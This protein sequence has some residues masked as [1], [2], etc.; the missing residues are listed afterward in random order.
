MTEKTSETVARLYELIDDIETAMLVTRRPD[1]SLVSRP[2]ANQERAPGA[3]FWFAAE[4]DSDKVEEIRADP[5]VNLTYYK[6]R[7]REW[8]SVAGTAEVSKDRDKIRQLY[9][10]DW[11][12]WFAGL[13]ADDPEAGTPDDPRIVLIGVRASSARDMTNDKPRPVVLF[14]VARAMV[15]GRR[16]EMG[17]VHE[18]SG[19]AIR[20]AD[21]R[22]E[23]ADS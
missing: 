8:V 10:P 20:R 5:H 6:D 14:E 3:D 21:P 4:D 23:R 9:K 7:T 1:G 17:E 18:V 15:S 22:G 12:F 2:M 13:N 16:P 19:E 11:K